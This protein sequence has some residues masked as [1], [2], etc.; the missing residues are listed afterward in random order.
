MKNQQAEKRLMQF[1]IV[2]TAIGFYSMAQAQRVN[3]PV[4]L[5]LNEAQTVVEI[6][7]VG[8]CANDNHNGCIE[9]AHG[10]QGRL[11]FTLVGNNANQCNRPD[12]KKW[13][14][15]EAYLGGKGSLTKP[16]SWGG[17]QNDS[18]VKAD[19]NFVN[20]TTGQLKKESGSNSNSIVIFDE[21]MALEWYNIWYKVTIVCV[22]SDGN[23]V[24]ELVAD[25]RIKNGGRQ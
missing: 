2:L 23:T 19:F 16:D 7:T 11:N 3:H 14:I 10:T 12:G 18:K 8:K 15:G 6:E 24:G 5:R 9:V 25:P 1:L 22:D 20:A 13:E 4:Q 21:N 17:F